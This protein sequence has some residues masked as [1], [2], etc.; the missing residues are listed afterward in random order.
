MGQ[1]AVKQGKNKVNVT[2]FVQPRMKIVS[3]LGKVNNRGC[4]PTPAQYTM[5]LRFDMLVPVE[6]AAES[7]CN[8]SISGREVLEMKNETT[9]WKAAQIQS[10]IV[11]LF[12]F[13][14]LQSGVLAKE[15]VVLKTWALTYLEPVEIWRILSEDL[16]KLGIEVDL[17]NGSIGEWVGDIIRNE[18][19]YHIVTMTWSGAPERIEPSF[20]LTE[21]FHTSRA[22]AGGRNYGNYINEDY[23]KLID[24]QLREMDPDKRKSLIW[25]AQE[26]LHEDNAFFPIYHHDMVQAYNSERIAGVIPTMGSCIGWPY[27]P[28]T[29]FKARPIGKV[30]EPRIVNRKDLMS[31]NPFTANEAQTMGW[32]RMIYDTFA[33]RDKDS[34]LIPW[35]AESWKVV[36]DK[37]VEIVLRDGMT[38]HDGNPVTIDDAIFTFAY[39]M[40]WKFPMF[41]EA[42][43]TIDRVE[44][45]GDRSM[46]FH[47]KQPYSPFVANILLNVFIAPKH[48]WEKIPE[49]VD[50]A[51]PMDWTNPKP[52]GSGPYQLVEWNKKEYFHLKANKEHFI[53]PNFDGLYYIFVPTTEGMIAMLEKGR[54]EFYGFALDGVQAKKLDALPHIST[55]RVA[56]HSL[57]ELRPNF[58]MRPM[59]DPKFRQAFQL[60]INRKA[61][62]DIVYQGEG[63][64]AHN[65]P[66]TPLNKPWS[67]P[68]VPVVEYDLE[69][70]RNILE[71]AGYSWDSNGKLC[72]PE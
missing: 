1:P 52:V 19:P 63:V 53:K 46:R 57:T 9:F 2:G 24:A 22:L 50:V 51:N 30:T 64:V 33:K 27:N 45:A 13:L 8:G 71:S 72:Y 25:Q 36:N 59:N 23:D 37:T 48:I 62:L 35:A 26:I 61:L 41:S 54:A 55:V 29:Y 65:T 18:N 58:K 7:G 11:V 17:R 67:N 32:M 34:E 38:F 66:I 15:P 60:S 56:N 69:K 39:I 70:A 12:F 43:R 20:F 10:L 68:N 31:T 3:A 44:P 28:W 16:K 49:T 14:F 4:G 42:W 21:L 6:E 47:L 40:Q 5:R